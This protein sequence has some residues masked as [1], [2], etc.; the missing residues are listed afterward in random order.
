GGLQRADGGLPAGAGALDEHVDLAHAVLH[1]LPGRVLGG[2]L[3][4]ERG[5]LARALETDVAGR[6]PADHRTGRVGDRHDR[7]VEGAL[8]VRLTVRDVLASLAPDL[9]DGTG[10]LASL[11]GHAITFSSSVALLAS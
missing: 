2:H 3:G 5:G 6:G 9:L 7:V 11:G 10:G 4:G 8:D 1:R